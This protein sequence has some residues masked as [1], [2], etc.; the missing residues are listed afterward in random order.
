[1]K[2]PD[3]AVD[4]ISMFLPKWR[5][6]SENTYHRSDMDKTVFETITNIIDTAY[7]YN[8]MTSDKKYGN[9]IGVISD[10][11]KSLELETIVVNDNVVALGN[12]GNE[13]RDELRLVVAQQFIYFYE[14]AY[15]DAGDTTH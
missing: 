9:F 15:T 6:E 2:T 4:F 5:S 12:V 3:A 14:T 10:S 13:K 7:I 8:L 1:M 11:V